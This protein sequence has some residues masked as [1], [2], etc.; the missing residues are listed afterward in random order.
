LATETQTIT[1][2]DNIVLHG[3]DGSL[4]KQPAVPSHGER[5]PTVTSSID[6][7]EFTC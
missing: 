3:S 2:G 6:T 1:V 7:E 5:E 4:G